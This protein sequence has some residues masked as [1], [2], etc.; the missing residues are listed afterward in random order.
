MIRV[1]NMRDSVLVTL[2]VVSD[3]AYAWLAISDYTPLMRSRIQRNPFSVLKLRATFLKLVSILDAPLVRIN[4]ANSPDLSS[5]SQYYST[6]VAKFMRTVLQVIPENMFAILSE[7]VRINAS[8]LQQLP[9]KVVRSELREWS[10]L[11][12]RHRLARATH[13][14]SVLTE[15]VLNM[16]S[17]VLGTVQVDPKELLEEGIR[18]ELVRQLSHAL[19]HGLVFKQGKP[20]ELEASLKRLSSQL[21]GF[22]LA[23]E[24]ISDYVKICGLKLW[25]E[26]LAGVL[27]FH[28]EQ[29]CNAFLK[30]KVHSWQ[31][32]FVRAA[33]AAANVG[34]PSGYEQHSFFGRLVREMVYLTSPRRSVYSEAMGGW[35]DTQGRELVGGRLMHL[36]Q[37]S[38]G[39][40]GLRGIG[41]TLGFMVTAQLHRF[42]RV[43]SGLVSGDLLA[44]L[45]VLSRALHPTS[46]LP[47]KPQKQY[48]AITTLGSRLMAEIHETVWRCGAAQL[49]R[50]HLAS[51]L[52]GSTRIDCS[53]LA[54]ILATADAALLAELRADDMR[55]AR[56]NAAAR[57]GAALPPDVSGP[58]PSPSPS[59]ATTVDGS[60]TPGAATPGT[61]AAP[62]PG[63]DGAAARGLF[64]DLPPTALDTATAD[65]TPY[66]DASGLVA[67]KEAVLVVAPALPRLPLAL[68]VF[69]YAQLGKMQWSSSLAA[70]SEPKGKLTEDSID[71][72]PLV[73]GIACILHQF[74]AE[75]TSLY[76]EYLMQLLRA[77]LH[78]AFSASGKPVD[79]PL[80]AVTLMHYIEL[81][82]RHAGIDVPGLELYQTAV[83]M[84]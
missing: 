27:N 62:P 82:S 53:L 33:E 41:S 52:G 4:E 42:V 29:E 47:D 84:G 65:L 10:Q 3:M 38:I 58:P 78:S 32:T 24:Y 6:E 31:S 2:A 11:D 61:A 51:A 80:E 5:V 71:G 28:V 14:V 63:G 57:S 69:T 75:A 72:V 48:Q 64:E 79:P 67:P 34:A 76:V 19:Q 81:F 74:N 26:E 55:R 15:G 46:T 16:Q 20:Q 77:M 22:Q 40:C 45:D 50:A 1:V 70:L 73:S 7:V 36:L 30:R 37:I 35:V 59:L 56:A 60:A 43:Y 17:T 39:R 44:G 66:L 8:E 12:P 9:V 68:A 83:A 54:T 49:L 18:A 21:Q 23:L 25:Q 13:R